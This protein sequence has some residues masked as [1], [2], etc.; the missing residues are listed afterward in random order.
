MASNY[1]SIDGPDA[2]AANN[3]FDE[4]EL[5]RRSGAISMALK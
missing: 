2:L 3:K 5:A 4:L 1:G